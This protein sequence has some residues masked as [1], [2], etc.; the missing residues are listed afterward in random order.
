MVFNC[1]GNRTM[2]TIHVKGVLA[3]DTHGKFI[4]DANDEPVDVEFHLTGEECDCV[5]FMSQLF[6]NSHCHMLVS[7]FAEW[8]ELGMIDQWGEIGAITNITMNGDVLLDITEEYG[9]EGVT[10][11]YLG[12]FDLTRW[13]HDD[14][15]KEM[16]RITDGATPTR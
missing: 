7:D 6:H 9:V 15:I 5:D 16:W 12:S 14:L 11:I 8:I 10:P 4:L 2:I 3:K 13:P 1:I